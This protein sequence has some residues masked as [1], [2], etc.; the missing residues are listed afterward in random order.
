MLTITPTQFARAA[1]DIS[2]GCQA[3]RL[4]LLLAWQDVKQ[5][6]RRSTLGPIWLTISMSIQI[7]VIGVLSAYLFNS[8][9]ERHLPYVCA[10]MVFW[11]FFNQSINEG[12]S[13]F[14]NS[15]SYLIQIR[16]PYSMYLIQVLFRNIISLGHNIITYIV[17]AIALLVV[18]GPAMLLFPIGFAL[19]VLCVA[20]MALI[21]GTL[22]VR[23]RDIPLTIQNVFSILF[24]LTPL[25]YQPEQ[26]GSKAFLAQWNPFTHMIALLREPLLGG[27]PTLTNWLV[28]LALTIVGWGG[29]FLFFCKFRSRIV[30]WL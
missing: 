2:G 20:W 25:M 3:W 27:S 4:G 12:A 1:A 24:W 23:Y 22:S 29:T 5:R 8:P 19:N 28:V 14:I 15:S 16:R 6:Y 13:L 18:P 11:T 26:L 21:A 30:Y 10:G 9:V 17:V 7:F